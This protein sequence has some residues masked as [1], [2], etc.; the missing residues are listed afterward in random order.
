[1]TIR[2]RVLGVVLVAVKE[3]DNTSYLYLVKGPGQEIKRTY[4]RY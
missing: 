4:P 1:M 2:V 3:A